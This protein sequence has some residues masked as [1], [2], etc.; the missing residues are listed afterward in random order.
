[1]T[2]PNTRLVLV[3]ILAAA[4]FASYLYLNSR[5]FDKV[6]TTDAVE[7]SSSEEDAESELKAPGKGILPDVYLLKKVVETGKRLM[8]NQ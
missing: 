3:L 6:T 2:K 4:S 5:T 8:P 7:A 1:M